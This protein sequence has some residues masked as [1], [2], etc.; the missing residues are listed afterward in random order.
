MHGLRHVGLFIFNNLNLEH[1]QDPKRGRERT[2]VL[3]LAPIKY[4]F[5]RFLS[6]IL[7]Y[8]HTPL[9]VTRYKLNHS[10]K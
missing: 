5:P 8:V 7:S 6:K 9:G 4:V 3:K 1:M 10:A 2:R